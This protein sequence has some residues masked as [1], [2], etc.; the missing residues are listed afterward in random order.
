MERTINKSVESKTTRKLEL[1]HSD[2]AGPIDPPAYDGSRYLL[3]F[4][5]DFTRV[6]WIRTIALKSQVNV[7]F[8]L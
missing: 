5:D 2:M 4:T 3:T 6:V 1:V 8:S 7:V